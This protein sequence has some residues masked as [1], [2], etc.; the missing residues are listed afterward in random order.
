MC[1]KSKKTIWQKNTIVYKQTAAPVGA[2]ETMLF[3]MRDAG[4]DAGLA[5]LLTK[6]L[7]SE[8]SFTY[9]SLG[10]LVVNLVD[11]LDDEANLLFHF[12]NNCFHDVGFLRVYD[13]G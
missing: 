11:V 10:G 7:E 5:I 8:G 1:Q 13:I 2:A 3:R 9:A 4:L 12:C 6:L